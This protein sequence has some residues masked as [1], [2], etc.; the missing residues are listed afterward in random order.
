MRGYILKKRKNNEKEL[1]QEQE[2]FDLLKKTINS[3]ILPTAII[4]ENKEIFATNHS[5]LKMLLDIEL[6]KE[7]NSLNSSF[8]EILKKL[9]STDKN[10]ANEFLDNTNLV[11]KGSAPY[12]SFEFAVDVH[13]EKVWFKARL[14]HLKVFSKTWIIFSLENIKTAKEIEFAKKDAAESILYNGILNSNCPYLVLNEGIIE[15]ANDK[16]NKAMN[17]TSDSVIGKDLYEF[18][19]EGDKVKYEN[20]LISKIGKEGEIRYISNNFEPFIAI[21]KFWHFNYCGMKKTVA[22]FVDRTKEILLEEEIEAVNLQIDEF[23]ERSCVPIIITDEDLNI[24]RINEIAIFFTEYELGEAIDNLTLYNI[25]DDNYH[26]DIRAI[27]SNLSD[28]SMLEI[29]IRTK[30]NNTKRAICSFFK[31]PNSEH[32]AAQFIDLSSY[33]R[34]MQAVISKESVLRDLADNIDDLIWMRD[35]KTGKLLYVSSNSKEK[36]NIG[37][38][39]RADLITILYNRVFNE[40]LKRVSDAIKALENEG[41]MIDE[42]FRIEV[43]G[44]I[45]WAWLRTFPIYSSINQ[46]DL[47]RIVGVAQD[48]SHRKQI[49]I[50][51][52]NEQA[53]YREIFNSANDGIFI[54]DYETCEVIDANEYAYKTLHETDLQTLKNQWLLN[55]CAD[56]KD[57]TSQKAIEKIKLASFGEQQIF[58]WKIKT[59]FGKI[60]WVEVNLKLALIEGKKRVI[61][62]V[63]EISD[64]K[65]IENIIKDREE[66]LS[67][68]LSSIGNPLFVVNIVD[69]G[70]DFIITELNP[71]FAHLFNSS[72]E[73]LLNNSFS[74]L[75]ASVHSDIFNQFFSKLKE[76]NKLKSKVIWEHP[77]ENEDETTHWLSSFTPIKRKDGSIFQIISASTSITLQKQAEEQILNL[78]SDL[79]SKIRSRTKELETTLQE[80]NVEMVTRKKM[81]EEL[82]ISQRELV[83]ALEN[84]KKLSEMK[85]R[86]ISMM[87]HEYR[88]PLTVILTSSMLLE[89]FYQTRDDVLFAKYSKNMQTTINDMIKTLENVL[90]AGRY[91]NEALKAH[92]DLVDINELFSKTIIE[93]KTLDK[94][95]HIITSELENLR[96]RSDYSLIKTIVLNLLLNA[97]KYSPEGSEI[98]LSAKK[99]DN[100]LIIKVADNGIGIAE[101]DKDRIF[102]QFY[103]GAQVLNSNIAGTGLGLSIVKSCIKALEG[104]VELTT[105]LGEGSSF[106]ISLPI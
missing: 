33:D 67:D 102:E 17:L 85:T 87:S 60:K 26:K 81:E 72:R 7:I 56:G 55:M 31:L 58:E 88:T 29:N 76:C 1:Q 75:S 105:K 14:N 11:L 48:I 71:A 20:L 89:K 93:A 37:A 41:K 54:H 80:L 21:T 106:V 96:I 103:R 6:T 49:E 99:E 44:E 3:I 42:Q 23:L 69:K 94:T 97:Q 46:G 63:R 38:Y 74:E 53:N 47:L 18:V 90:A 100:K 59:I 22:S 12:Y 50:S 77:F 32:F 91:D 57:Y 19:N 68:V 24:K 84:E 70:D 51:L 45:R 83:G 10:I 95:S 62:I 30:R 40:D 52:I 9:T 101:S 13:S 92:Y 79:E 104:N 64:R 16:F 43:K 36:W 65:K 8:I 86:F 35:A 5:W 2:N 15:F 61:A 98:L 34:S 78:N 39:T 25:I 82:L 66:F 27:A 4:N 73:E 28:V